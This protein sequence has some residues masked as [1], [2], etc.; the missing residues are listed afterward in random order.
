MIFINYIGQQFGCYKI[1][2][3]SKKKGEK[4]RTLYEGECVHCGFIKIYPISVFK[5]LQ[6]EK[7]CHKSKFGYDY[8][9]I[10]NERIRNI[11]AAMC[12]RCYNN[13]NSGFKKYGA[14]G[15]QI[16]EEW[17][18][19]PKLFEKWAIEHGYDNEL[20]I[21]RINPKQGYSPDNCRWVTLEMNAKWKSTSHYITV[22]GIE[23]TGRG[24]AKRL[25]FNKNYINKKYSDY[26]E[27]YVIKLISD[28]LNKNNQVAS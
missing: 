3:I 1:I 21:D 7:C 15:I 14:K 19:N 25:G 6:S 4:N 17:L 20:T 27:I 13:K 28:L 10:K 9:S 5:R 12:E 23:D 11:F 16:C 8:H 22:N 2:G 18:N 24:W 26:G